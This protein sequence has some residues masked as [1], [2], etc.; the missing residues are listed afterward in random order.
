MFLLRSKLF[1]SALA[2]AI[3]WWLAMQRFGLFAL[4][5]IAFVP[6]LLAASEI[7]PLRARFFYGWAAGVL[8]FAFHNWWMLPT[9]AK[10]GGVIGATPVVGA[11]LGVL[12][13]VL[14]SIIHGLGVAILV[15]LWNPRSWFFK[16]VPLALPLFVAAWWWLFEWIRSAGELAHSWGAPAFS[17]WRDAALLQSAFV[18]GQ[19]GLSALCVWFAACLALWLRWEY[20]ARA[21]VLWR[22]P[23][24]LFLILHLWGAWRIQQYDRTPHEKLRLL[25]VATNISSL[26]KNRT[27][28]SH[29]SAAE[30]A[31]L[32]YFHDRQSS[33]VN[34]QSV[35]LIAWPET[36][37]ALGHV[38]GGAQQQRALESLSRELQTPIVVGAQTFGRGGTLSQA[39]LSNAAVLFSPDASSQR[40]GKMRVVP[41][42]ERA[43]LQKWLPFLSTFAPNPP[44][45]PATQV[46]PL[47]VATRDGILQLG[48][49]ICF[50]SC[51]QQPAQ[52][53]V[54]RGA[55]VLLVLTNDEW[56]AGTTAPWEH[57]A[58]SA[59][60]AAENGAPVAQC[61]NGGY[62]LGT[63]ARGR[64]LY[65]PEFAPARALLLEIPRGVRK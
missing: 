9:I 21:P 18:I 24:A 48:T 44:V 4:G 3:L 38:A 40:S 27:G 37:V 51:F 58:M 59:V 36:T 56:L 14:V 11:M 16:R 1:L 53:L 43:P 10:A 32:S 35:D 26:E 15:A 65:S 19:H 6:L 30:R 5:W 25:L 13:L 8:C 22:V 7:S 61:A 54:E 60:R 52:T 45:L 28:E 17:Q 2:T 42:G 62:V 34:R 57:A 20:S 55:G 63:D 12:A 33:I 31:T 29:F 64:F 47:A 50:E 49:L 23:V 46:A 41:F 39:S